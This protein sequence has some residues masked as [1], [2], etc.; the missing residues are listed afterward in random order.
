MTAS[1]TSSPKQR[2]SL[3]AWHGPAGVYVDAIIAAVWIPILIF[4][5]KSAFI[6]ASAT[7][8]TLC[9]SLAYSALK[10]TDLDRWTPFVTWAIRLAAL[11]VGLWL[12]AVTP[13]HAGR[14]IAVVA[15][16]VL[17]VACD[18]A[19]SRRARASRESAP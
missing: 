17:Y 7:A 11:V 16:V 14:F 5:R 3:W 6:M 18:R 4:G 13:A 19:V 1:A 15:Y 2:T 12:F 9:A 8:L 10:G